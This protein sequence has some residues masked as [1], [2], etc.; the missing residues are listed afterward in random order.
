MRLND[1]LGSGLAINID[2]DFNRIYKNSTISDG[3]DAMYSYSRNSL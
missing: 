1:L 2:I 3:L